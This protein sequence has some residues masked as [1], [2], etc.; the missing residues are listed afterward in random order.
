M[1]DKGIWQ[2]REIRFDIPNKE[3]VTRKGEIVIDAIKNIEDTKGNPDETG[4]LKITNLRLLWYS[5]INTQ[6]NLSIGYDCIANIEVKVIVS[7][8]SGSVQSLYLRCKYKQ[9]KFEFIF[10]SPLEDSQKL[11]ATFQAVCRS[12]ETTKLYRDLRLRSA[13]IQEK[14]LILLPREKIINKYNGVWNLSADQGN[15]G[16]F[17]VTN[18][19]VVWF[20]N[21]SENFNVSVPYIQIKI[22]RKRD[23]KYGLAV[24]IETSSLSGNYVL[25]FQSDNLEV[26]FQELTKLHKIHYENPIFGVEVNI[27]E[28]RTPIDDIKVKQLQ[29]DVEIIETDYNDRQNHISNYVTSEDKAEVISILLYTSLTKYTLD[30]TRDYILSRARTCSRKASPRCDH[31]SVMEDHKSICRCTK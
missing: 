20:A 18:V 22:I 25:G 7:N 30:T 17:I 21:L 4:T 27:E 24:V 8:N 9:S 5:E 26:M 28:S 1:D 19:R 23:S 14:N 31:R 11:Y 3:I 12:Y 16:T 10:S 2:D 29:E 6:I 15:V 13:I